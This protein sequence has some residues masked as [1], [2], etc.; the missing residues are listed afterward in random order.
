MYAVLHE[1]LRDHK[2][3]VIFTCFGP[4]HFGYIALAVLGTLVTLLLLR[5]RNA[6]TRRRVER[7]LIG[8]A[9]GL[10]LADFFLMPFAYG[11]IDLE[12]LPFHVCTATC[13]LCFL[14]NHTRFWQKYRIHFALVGML[15]NLG[16]LIYPAGVMWHAVHPLSYRVVQTLLFHGI[17]SVYGLVTLIDHK[18]GLPFRRWKG[19]L[20]VLAGLILW[21]VLGNLCYNGTVGDYDHFFNWFFVVRDPFWLLDP[22]ISPYV[23]PFVNLV[24]FSAAE[25]LVYALDRVVRKRGKR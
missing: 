9:F 21:A 20:G 11:E 4:W 17:M 24:L 15:S 1:L 2:G 16:Y 12:K 5:G 22:A 25:L 19:D 3:G 23:M 14:S 6:E 13:V 7:G 18:E 8:L 10:Y